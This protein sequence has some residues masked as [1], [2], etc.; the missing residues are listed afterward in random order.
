[1]ILFFRGDTRSTFYSR[2]SGGRP[3]FPAAGDCEAFRD[4]ILV[5]IP[6]N[7]FRVL[8]ITRR[9]IFLNVR[10]PGLISTGGEAVGRDR[11]T[12]RCNRRQRNGRGCPP[13][14]WNW[15]LK[16]TARRPFHYPDQSLV[17]VLGV[18]DTVA[19]EGGV[20]AALARSVDTSHPR[21]T[22]AFG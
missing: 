7:A 22:V 18:P 20:C 10:R 14:F 13:R 4:G 21:H 17:G 11:S 12:G 15:R 6:A 16:P 3:P 9:R 2:G 1:M 5:Y 19:G 8:A